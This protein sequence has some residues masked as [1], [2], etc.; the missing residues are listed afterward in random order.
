MLSK[1]RCLFK[2]NSAA[3]EA[4]EGR[5]DVL[6]S[7]LPVTL[8]KTFESVDD[9]WISATGA[10]NG[11]FS[12]AQNGDA[13]ATALTVTGGSGVNEGAGNRY[14]I[15]FPAHPDGVNYEHTLQAYNGTQANALIPHV[16]AKTATSMTYGFLSG[17]DGG[18]T[19]DYVRTQ[20]D[21]VIHSTETV[22]ADVEVV[23]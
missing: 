7:Q 14:T 19:D 4:L 11:G 8:D 10:I 3:I 6:E 2:Q 16:I 17:D 21:V 23:V 22:L 15:T 1:L 20:H 18:G 9:R 5:V 12:D 13:T